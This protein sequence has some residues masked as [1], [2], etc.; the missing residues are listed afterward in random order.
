M[1]QGRMRQNTY[2]RIRMTIATE[3]ASRQWDKDLKI[4]REKDYLVY[5]TKLSFE[6]KAFSDMLGLKLVMQTLYQE[7][8]LW[9][10]LEK[11]GSKLKKK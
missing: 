4:L 10:I 2:R 1:L 6:H 5:P 8:T 9:H 3:N 7:F 11:G